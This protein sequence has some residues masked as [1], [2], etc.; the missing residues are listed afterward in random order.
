MPAEVF[1]S[2]NCLIYNV[3]HVVDHFVR[4]S[5][6][7]AYPEGISHGNVGIFK[8]S[9]YPVSVCATDTVKRRVLDDIAAEKQPGL[10]V[11]GFN[12]L[13]NVIPLN[14][15]IRLYGHNESEP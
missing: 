8:A 10:Y 3:C 12:E 7:Y 2:F 4:H 6:I 11:V 9:G 14:T 15:R 1:C 13:H 5:R